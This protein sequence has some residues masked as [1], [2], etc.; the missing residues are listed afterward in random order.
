MWVFPFDFLFSFLYV[1]VSAVWLETVVIIISY[2]AH[3]L[4]VWEMSLILQRYGSIF[5][6]WILMYNSNR[7]ALA[8]AVHIFPFVFQPRVLISFF[9]CRA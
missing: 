6:A 5:L 9:A 8:I 2:V 4:F 7:V 3:P 1:C